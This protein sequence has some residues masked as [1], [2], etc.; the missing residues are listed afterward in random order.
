MDGR[1][2]GMMSGGPLLLLYASMRRS[3]SFTSAK[4][5]V[6]VALSELN[7]GEARALAPAKPPP[8]AS[9]NLQ[10]DNG[11]FLRVIVVEFISTF[12]VGYPDDKGG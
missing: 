9:R 10:S 6:T 4:V 2:E 12:L 3:V 5:S 11:K 8:A 1:K 7:S